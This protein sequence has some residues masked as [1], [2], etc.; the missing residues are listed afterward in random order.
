MA[1]LEE[2]EFQGTINEDVAIVHRI[3]GCLAY[4][5]LYMI[6][7]PLRDPTMADAMKWIEE[8]EKEHHGG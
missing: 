2:Y 8:H 4:Q 1:N 5:N 7:N 3:N 6:H